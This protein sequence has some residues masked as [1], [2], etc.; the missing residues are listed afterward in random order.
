MQRGKAEGRGHGAEMPEKGERKPENGDR[1]KEGTK[2][3]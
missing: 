2:I 3:R 1:E